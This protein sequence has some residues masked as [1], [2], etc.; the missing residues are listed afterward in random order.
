M[1]DNS[2]MVLIQATYAIRL[3][4]GYPLICWLYAHA[5]EGKGCQEDSLE[6]HWRRWRALAF[7]VSSEYRGCHPD[8]LSVSVHVLDSQVIGSDLA[9]L[10]G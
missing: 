5:Q 8:D 3:K 2:F 7:N 9:R 1:Y 10:S 4:T 6:I